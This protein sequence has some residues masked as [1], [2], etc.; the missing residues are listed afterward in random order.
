MN[1]SGGKDRL[2]NIYDTLEYVLV[3]ILLPKSP[4][5]S[6]NKFWSYFKHF[7]NFADNDINIK[8]FGHDFEILRSRTAYLHLLCDSLISD[9]K[10]SMETLI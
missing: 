1:N 10:L 6:S 7:L 3:S 4:K 9:H 2:T 8:L 5:H